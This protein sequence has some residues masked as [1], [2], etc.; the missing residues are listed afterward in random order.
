[1]FIGAGLRKI[2]KNTLITRLKNPITGESLEYLYAKIPTKNISKSDLNM[3]NLGKLRK[4]ARLKH[5]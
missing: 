1:M 4:E 3:K 2:E 5:P